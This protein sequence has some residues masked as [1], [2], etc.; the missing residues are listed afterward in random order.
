MDL[1]QI[2]LQSAVIALLI[3]V[4]IAAAMLFFA[5]FVLALVGLLDPSEYK[6]DFDFARNHPMATRFI[7][8]LWLWFE[9][10]LLLAAARI[11]IPRG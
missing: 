10:M 3:I 9:L 5:S 8:L 4:G 2:I 11:G 1:V 6:L 7:S